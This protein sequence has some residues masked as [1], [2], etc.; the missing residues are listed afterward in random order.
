MLNYDQPVKCE[1]PVR[2]YETGNEL[3]PVPW[4]RHFRL[5]VRCSVFC[6]A[7][8]CMHFAR[9]SEHAQEKK[10]KQSWREEM[11]KEKGW[12]GREGREMLGESVCYLVGLLF[13]VILL[14]KAAERMSCWCTSFTR[15]IPGS[16]GLLQFFTLCQ[17]LLEC[18]FYSAENMAVCLGRFKTK[19]PLVMAR[20][21]AKMCRTRKF[22]KQPAST[23]CLAFY[24]LPWLHSS[25]KKEM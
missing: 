22:F 19:I 9:T 24:L 11:K 23:R 5:C 1:R 14:S 17:E 21:R 6:R 15:S 13:S 7:P 25:R 12:V 8:K 4:L 3:F 2:G 20:K 10:G 18:L 16:G